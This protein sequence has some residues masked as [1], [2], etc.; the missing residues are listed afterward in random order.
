MDEVKPTGRERP[1]EHWN[2]RLVREGDIRD[3]VTRW[4]EA[5][6]ERVEKLAA[7][8]GKAPGAWLHDALEDT[9]RLGE[10]PWRAL[11]QSGG[12]HGPLQAPRRALPGRE[13]DIIDPEG[14]I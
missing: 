6:I 9:V 12:R 13:T 1:G 10:L 11:A 3:T 14:R 4:L 2:A 7:L 8:E 5:N